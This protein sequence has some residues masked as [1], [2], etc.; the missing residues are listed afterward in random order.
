MT[1]V[2]ADIAGSTAIGERLDPEALRRVQ[3]RYFDAMKAAIERHGGT[4]EKYIGDAVMAVFGIPRLHEDDPLRAVRAANE[5]QAALEPLNADLRAEHDVEIRIRIGVNTGEV[6]AGDP[7]AGQALVTGDTVNVAARLEQAAGAG[8][9]LLGEPT[10]RLVKDAVEVEEVA[11]LD[12]KGKSEPV[13]AHRL[14]AVAAGVMGHARNLDSPMVGRDEELDLLRRALHRVATEPTSH[15]FTLL[16]PAG[17]GKSRLVGE[18]LRGIDTETTVLHGRCLSYGEGITYF[19]LGEIVRQAASIKDDDPAATAVAAL[20]DLLR[21]ADDG[22]RITRLIGGIF[23]WADPATPD[24]AAWAVRKLFEHLARDHPLVLLFDDIH[25]AE[26]LL[27]DLIEYLAD[28]TRDAAVLIVCVARPELLELR[29]GWAGG[30]VNATTI[31]LE[32]LGGDDAAALLAN[33]LGDADL[34]TTARDRILD[35]ADGNPLFV[36]EM[37]GML[38]DDGL[39][40]FEGGAWRPV[41]DLA[42]LTVPPTIALLLAA[43]LDRLEAEER[44]V[45]ERGAVEGQV[46]HTGAVSSLAPEALRGQVRPRLLA[47]ARKEL[48]RP[49]RPEFAGEDAFRFRH[50]L[51]RDAAYQAM[52]KEQRADLHE[53]FARWLTQVSG[54]RIGEYEEIL[55]HHLEQ[56]YRYRTE[57]GLSDDRTRELGREAG[58]AIFRSAERADQAA[59]FDGTL[60][61]ERAAPLLDGEERALAIVLLGVMCEQLSEYAKAVGVLE[62]FVASEDAARFPGLRIRAEL[63]A[64][65]AR[66]QLDPA[67]S[68][69][70]Q[71][72]TAERLLAEAEALGDEEARM[73]CIAALGSVSFWEGRC[74]DARRS[75]EQIL[76]SGVPLAPTVR[77]V[78]GFRFISDAYFGGAP[79]HEGFG[80][81]ERAREVFGDTLF[82]ELVFHNNRASLFAMLDRPDEFDRELVEVDRLFPEIGAAGQF[83]PRAQVIGQGMIRLGRLDDAEA[84]FRASKTVLDDRGDTAFNVNITAELGV[85]LIEQGRVDEGRR[86]IDDAR[87]M[88]SDDDFAGLTVIGWGDAL[89]ASAEGDHDAAIA[90]ADQAWAHMAPTDYLCFQAKT[91]AIRGEVLAAAGRAD[92]AAAAFAEAIALYERKGNVADVR[93]L[94]ERHP[95]LD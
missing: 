65:F 23:G 4:V 21:D 7:S 70:D 53:A 87:P 30:K 57:L 46:F 61:F 37:V 38:I 85:L 13:P 33:L 71:R 82:A 19:A 47:L 43:R 25:W 3:V 10:Y 86:L 8:E 39:L 80:L 69:A 51:I 84:L 72:A 60:L 88:A 44:A 24:D 55:A 67:V 90:A 48:I 56:A 54:D 41:D 14:T 20:G 9:V 11:P 32:P 42:D 52:P 27:L 66:A 18:F 59:R 62:P 95:E 22:E 81:L 78:M 35:A 77:R 40:R 36:E 26:P 17:V 49:D 5:M 34:P 91:H 31:L 63:S 15:L 73:A 50:L 89:L 68:I 45:I 79:V 74:G 75:S 93:R 16:G 6:V 12:L 58:R 28:W 94:R 1:I 83:T 2:F 29:P 92:E 64:T 76:D